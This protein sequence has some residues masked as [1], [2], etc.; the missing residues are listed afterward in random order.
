MVAKRRWIV[1]RGQIALPVGENEPCPRFEDARSF[2]KTGAL[3]G[4][5]PYH[6]DA[7]RAVEGRSVEAGRIETSGLVGNG[8]TGLPHP[9]AR[10]LQRDIGN[11]DAHESRSSGPRDPLSGSPAPT[12]HVGN[13]I[14]GTNM[15]H[16]GHL[17]QFA[18]R[19][20]AVGA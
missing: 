15:E 1:G 14:A 12:A 7:H 3:V 5:R 10:L 18:E 6:V 16:V 11:V 13:L 17:P 8:D 2:R 20:V 19:Y 4:D 9:L